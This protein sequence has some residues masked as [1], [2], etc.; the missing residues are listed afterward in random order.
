MQP[1]FSSSGEDV[2]ECSRKYSTPSLPVET[3]SEGHCSG[4]GCWFCL[5]STMLTLSA[6]Q[7]VAG[8]SGMFPVRSRA[9][10]GA[11]SKRRRSLRLR[12]FGLAAGHE[13]RGGRE[14]GEDA[15][16]VRVDGVLLLG[17]AEELPRGRG[18]RG[19]L[20]SKQQVAEGICVL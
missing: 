8:Q 9:S 14:E 20:Y 16:Y 18:I 4:R 3:L 15:H 11:A 17:A 13:R 10:V 2:L 7:I 12:R 19:R 6:F 1:V 5:A